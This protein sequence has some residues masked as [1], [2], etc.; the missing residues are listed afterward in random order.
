MSVVSIVATVVAFA[1]NTLFYIFWA[2][3]VLDFVRQLR[4]DWKPKGFWLAV[5]VTILA[6]T[7]PILRVARKVIKPVRVGQVQ[8]DLAVFIVMVLLLVIAAAMTFL[9]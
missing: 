1:A 2:R 8:V 4:R 7:D 9:S 6:I 5:S 3:I